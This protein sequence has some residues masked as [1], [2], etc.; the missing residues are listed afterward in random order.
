M[1][2]RPG[3]TFRTRTWPWQRHPYIRHRR[4]FAYDD[5]SQQSF[6][7]S[8]FST[9]F[10]GGHLTQGQWSVDENGR[11]TSFWL[12]SYRATYDVSQVANNGHVTGLRFVDVRTRSFRRALPD[13]Q[14]KSPRAGRPGVLASAGF[15]AGGRRV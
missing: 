8:G 10:A 14:L 4:S 11:F 13:P 5:G 2:H 15:N 3:E 6:V 7:A 1:N 9:Y 12:P